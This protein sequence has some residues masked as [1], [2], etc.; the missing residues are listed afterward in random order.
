MLFLLLFKTKS[1]PSPKTEVWTLDW[2]LTISVDPNGQPDAGCGSGYG[3]KTGA[4]LVLGAMVEIYI[5]PLNCL[6]L[7]VLELFKLNLSL[8]FPP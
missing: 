6:D 5:L 3:K 1:T 4:L 8:A 2:S 7:S